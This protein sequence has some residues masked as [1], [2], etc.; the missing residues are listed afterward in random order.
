MPTLSDEELGIIF[1]HISSSIHR[2]SI[3]QVCKQWRRV[4]GITRLS[5]LVLDSNVIPKFLPRFPNLI[6]FESSTHITNTQLEFVAKTCRHIELVNLSFRDINRVG[7][8]S[9]VEDVGDM[10]L[11]AISKGCVKMERVLLRGR[12]KVGDLGVMGM[13]WS[14]FSPHGFAF[15]SRGKLVIFDVRPRSLASAPSLL[16]HLKYPMVYSQAEVSLLG[17]GTVT[18]GGRVGGRVGGGLRGGPTRGSLVLAPPG[19]G[20]LSNIIRGLQLHRKRTLSRSWKCKES[21][22]NSKKKIILRFVSVQRK[23]LN[24]SCSEISFFTT[25]KACSM[26]C[27]LAEA[28]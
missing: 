5:L 3:S 23:M 4:E 10:G 28:D 26:Q 6:K 14:S 22:D 18:G 9:G 1:S 13:T 25:S 7:D 21:H 24:N 15:I 8:E 27:H 16:G 11:Y 2:F 17:A 12:K 19:Q 20:T